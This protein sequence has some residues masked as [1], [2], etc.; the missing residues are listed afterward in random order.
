M[1]IHLPPLF[2][3]LG[4]LAATAVVSWIVFGVLVLWGFSS[5]WGPRLAVPATILAAVLSWHFF[6]KLT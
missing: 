3:I 2:T 1:T 4:V 5:D 6:W